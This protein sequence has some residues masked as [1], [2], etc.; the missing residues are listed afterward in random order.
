LFLYAEQ[1][2]RLKD[3]RALITVGT[4][5]IGLE[6][7]RL[8]LAEG[9]RLAITKPVLNLRHADSV[10]YAGTP[11]FHIEAACRSRRKPVLSERSDCQRRRLIQRGME[12]W[13]ITE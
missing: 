4:S 3:K 5:G 11:S 13:T 10:P 9:A 8:F 2:E 6:T 7:A 12:A 1:V